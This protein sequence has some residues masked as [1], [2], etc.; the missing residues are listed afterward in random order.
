MSGT[1][2]VWKAP[3]VEDERA[4]KR[5]LDD[6]YE[7]GDESAFE[8]SPDVERFYEE[9]IALWPP[10]A[11][12]EDDD[13]EEA[14]PTWASGEP[15]ASSRLV[16][17][18]YSWSAPGEMLDDIQ[19]LAVKHELVL[20]DPQGPDLHLPGE[21][22]DTP[23]VPTARDTLRVARVGLVAIAA[24][25]AAWYASIPILSWIVIG[26]AALV[27]LAAVLG[28]WSDAHAAIRHRRRP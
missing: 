15:E 9:L 2:V 13:H 24:A 16:S 11:Y 23:Y 8:P 1:L 28:I 10:R 18:D 19:R 17:M 3:L 4:A 22:A 21:V 12:D 14:V 7:T 27:V 5:L 20:Y 26:I 25:V 6:Y